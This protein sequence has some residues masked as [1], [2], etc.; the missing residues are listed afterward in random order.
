[1]T[2]QNNGGTGV[3]PFEELRKEFLEVSRKKHSQVGRSGAGDD[4]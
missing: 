3:L 2:F 1:M 4:G